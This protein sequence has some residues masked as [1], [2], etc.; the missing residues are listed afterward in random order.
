MPHKVTEANLANCIS[1]DKSFLNQHE[2]DLFL[3][4]TVIG[5]KKWII[6]N[7]VV[8]RISWTVAG[9]PPNAIPKVCLHPKKILLSV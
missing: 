3:K 6:Y 2:R 5:D 7:N 4:P 9:Q 1:I 8:H